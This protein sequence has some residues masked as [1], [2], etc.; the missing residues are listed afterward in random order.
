MMPLL[1]SSEFVMLPT[2]PPMPCTHTC[3]NI[4]CTLR[5][6]V[7]D[8]YRA[9]L[10]VV[11]AEVVRLIHGGTQGGG[12]LFVTQLACGMQARDHEVEHHGVQCR[13]FTNDFVYLCRCLI[14]V[15]NKCI[16]S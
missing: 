8:A 13:A 11:K 14:N 2:V 7:L 5:L 1:A 16:S 9:I 15:C 4:L 6:C 10:V 3:R 12:H